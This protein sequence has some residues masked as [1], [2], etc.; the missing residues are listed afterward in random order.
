MMTIAAGM[1][2]CG[3][4]AYAATFA[5]FCAILGAE[6]IQDRLRLSAACRCA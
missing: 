6:Q 3:M 4:I 1:A 5:S 2:S